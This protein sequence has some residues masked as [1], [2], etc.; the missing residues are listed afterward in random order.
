MCNHECISHVQSISCNAQKVILIRNNYFYHLINTKFTIFTSLVLTKCIKLCLLQS[1]KSLVSNRM[2]LY[3]VVSIK[4]QDR[5]VVVIL[6]EKLNISDFFIYF[7]PNRRSHNFLLLCL[8]QGCHF[9]NKFLLCCQ[10]YYKADGIPMVLF[11]SGGETQ[12]GC[13]WV[14]PLHDIMEKTVDNAS[15]T[16]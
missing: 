5:N 13:L 4:V 2:D 14:M 10:V 6:C 3:R 8:L 11:G 1:T 7:L 9:I 15:I 12:G 16:Y